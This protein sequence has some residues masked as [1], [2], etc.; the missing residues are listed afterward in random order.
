MSTASK[1]KRL[2]RPRPEPE[3]SL[4]Q[5]GLVCRSG[6]ISLPDAPAWWLPLVIDRGQLGVSGLDV[7]DVVQ[8]DLF[9]DAGELSGPHLPVPLGVPVQQ[10]QSKPV[11]LGAVEDGRGSDGP[12]RA[13]KAPTPLEIGD[14]PALTAHAGT[15]AVCHGDR[16][17]VA[18]KTCPPHT[19]T[20]TPAA[21]PPQPK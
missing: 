5:L 13:S 11:G 18:I 21:S 2:R 20:V 8:L 14:V 15:E 12:K 17:G 4:E 10:V 1:T 16:Q 7:E 19:P 3:P 9:S 6:V